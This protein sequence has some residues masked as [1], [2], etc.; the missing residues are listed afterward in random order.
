MQVHGNTGGFMS[1]DNALLVITH[2]LEKQLGPAPK[3]VIARQL[4]E[5]INQEYAKKHPG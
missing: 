5:L 3:S 2:Q 4:A 1:D